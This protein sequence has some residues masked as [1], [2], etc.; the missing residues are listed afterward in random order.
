MLW[1]LWRFLLLLVLFVLAYCRVPPGAQSSP[2]CLSWR[3]CRSF[4]VGPARWFQSPL[5]QFGVL[6]GTVL[7]N[8]ESKGG[9]G[10]GGIVKLLDMDA[11]EV[12]ALC[13][14][15]R[16]GDTVRFFLVLRKRVVAYCAHAPCSGDRCCEL[17]VYY[18]ATSFGWRDAVS[19]M[20]ASQRC[21]VVFLRVPQASLVQHS[22]RRE[23][24]NRT[25][26]SPQR[27]HAFGNRG[28]MR[29][30]PNTLLCVFDSL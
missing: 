23:R 14:N 24:S 28:A 9:G 29:D 10:S 19:F 11:R 15:H 25:Y 18:Q 4:F 6:P 16:M 26:A 3:F 17:H 22:R 1:L 2:C 7:M 13:H 12:G 27:R 20:P 8:L 30:A 21:N 5:R